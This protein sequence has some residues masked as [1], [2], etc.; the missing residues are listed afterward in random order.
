M[1]ELSQRSSLFIKHFDFHL[2]IFLNAP[3]VY[4][5]R[6]TWINHS[7]GGLMV[8]SKS[9]RAV[10]FFALTI[11]SW[12]MRATFVFR[13]FSHTRRA[14]S[15]FQG[16]YRGR[17]IYNRNTIFGS[18][19][20]EKLYDGLSNVWSRHFPTENLSFDWFFTEK[21]LLLSGFYFLVIF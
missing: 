14:L 1:I 7:N 21:V 17:L 9:T 8:I 15:V 6:F 3:V 12:I 16:M 10:R 13:K 11:H 4:H 2:F 20:F 5:G 19:E 18:F